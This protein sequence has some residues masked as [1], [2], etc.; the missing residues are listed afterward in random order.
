MAD[1]SDRLIRIWSDVLQAAVR[2]ND[3][4]LD[5]GGDS[6]TAMSCIVLMREAFGVE[7]TVGDFLV[8]DSTVTTFSGLID[9]GEA[10][11]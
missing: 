8:D 3:S 5:L 9:R 10:A 4:F 11:R 2:P 6:L 1:T 7:F